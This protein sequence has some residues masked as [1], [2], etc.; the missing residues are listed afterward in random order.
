MPSKNSVMELSCTIVAC[1][2]MLDFV[3]IVRDIED[4]NAG[5]FEVAERF[6]LLNSSRR[7]SLTMK[8]SVASVY[9]TENATS[10]AVLA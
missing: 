10:R 1:G 9:G 4:A 7:W 3:D 6:R 2:R 8:A 5:R